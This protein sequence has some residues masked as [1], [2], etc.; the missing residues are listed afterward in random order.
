MTDAISIMERGNLPDAL[1]RLAATGFHN[2]TMYLIL[3]DQEGLEVGEL[4]LSLSSQ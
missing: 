3:N 4:I 2:K 1:M